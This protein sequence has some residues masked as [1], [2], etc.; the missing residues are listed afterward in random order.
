MYNDN[1]PLPIGPP[2][3]IFTD[4]S[5]GF[6]YN[7]KVRKQKER[8]SA[9]IDA[10]AT[11]IWESFDQR[12]LDDWMEDWFFDANMDEQFADLACDLGCDAKTVQV[13]FSRVAK[14]RDGQQTNWAPGL[15]R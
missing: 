15:G 1:R 11:E 2:V 5:D 13:A 4:G 10:V 8:R 14:Y 9:R 3:R 6:D 7:A 12:D